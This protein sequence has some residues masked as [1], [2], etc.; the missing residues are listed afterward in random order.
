MSCLRKSCLF[1]G[2]TKVLA[3][4]YG[5]KAG[6]K[7][8]ENPEKAC[9]DVTWKPK[10][11]QIGEVFIYIFM[12][13]EFFIFPLNWEYHIFCCYVERMKDGIVREVDR[14]DK[15]T[16]FPLGFPVVF[17]RTPMTSSKA[18]RVLS[19]EVSSQLIFVVIVMEAFTRL[20]ERVVSMW[21]LSA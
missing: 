15:G 19:K 8:N 18:L 4:V 21:F 9:I 11:G 20:I 14:I 6:T 13:L 3:A 1:S 16:D 5:P 2:D 10:T 17:N 7:K 12:Y